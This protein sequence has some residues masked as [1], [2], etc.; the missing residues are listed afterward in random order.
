MHRSGAQWTQGGTFLTGLR[1]TRSTNSIHWRRPM[2]FWFGVEKRDAFDYSLMKAR[3][4][5][6]FIGMTS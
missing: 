3:A 4:L 1:R 5:L 2:S 6:A